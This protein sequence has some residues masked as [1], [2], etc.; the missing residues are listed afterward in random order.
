MNGNVDALKF[1]VKNGASLHDK[2]NVS[3]LQL[4]TV[5]AML[6]SNRMHE[7]IYIYMYTYV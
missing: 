3:N 4:L 1:L 6:P 2:D 5:Q 7:L